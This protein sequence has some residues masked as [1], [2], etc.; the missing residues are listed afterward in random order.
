M[1]GFQELWFN[2]ADA[3]EIEASDVRVRALCRA[4]WRHTSQTPRSVW[5]WQKEIDGKIY[6]VSQADAVEIQEKFARE[7]YFKQF[8]DELGD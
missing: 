5:M 3:L 6:S 2:K 1:P 7:D 8:P 4:G